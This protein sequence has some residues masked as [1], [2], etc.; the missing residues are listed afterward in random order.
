MI[1]EIR[2]NNFKCFEELYVEM[3]ELNVFAGINNMGKSTTIQALLLLRQAF[4]MNSINK[5][6]YLNGTLTNLG[7]GYDILYRNSESDKITI[8]LHADSVNIKNIYEYSKESDFQRVD[9]SNIDDKSFLEENLFGNNFSYVSAERRGPQRFY[10]SSYHEIYE[11]NQVGTKGEFYAAYLA[12]RG[13]TQRVVNESVLHHSI[14]SDL[15]IYQMEA[16]M[17]ELSPGINFQPKKYQEAGIV[18]MEYSISNELF[19]PVN[20]GFGLSYVAPIVLSLLKAEKG[21]L[22]IVENPE[23]HLHPRGQRKMGE[24]IARA[25]EGGV[26]V[27]VETHSDH[28]LNGIRLSV[29]NKKISKEKIR[30]NYFYSK[31]M[32]DDKLGEIIKHEK[33]SPMIMDDG[34]LSDWPEGFFDEWDK[35]LEELF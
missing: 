2:L 14:K 8:E 7:T 17:S 30:L 26:Q 27:V 20:V 11:Q 4:E 28:L 23:A 21:D 29:K 9:V 16:W 33:C 19:T 15:L 10:G 32:D 25:S 22:V 6:I 12:E 18:S 34:S 5:G 3:A 1:N 24:L 31:L 13:T 35:A